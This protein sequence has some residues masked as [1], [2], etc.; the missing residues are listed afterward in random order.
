M[1][2]YEVLGD[3]PANLWHTWITEIEAAVAAADGDRD[4]RV[5]NQPVAV[6]VTP[7]NYRLLFLQRVAS[8]FRGAVAGL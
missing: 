1:Y 8:A 3:A 6:A 5:L 7:P 4:T 2:T